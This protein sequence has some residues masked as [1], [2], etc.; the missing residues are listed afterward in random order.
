MEGTGV[1]GRALGHD[2]PPSPVEEER[3]GG[4]RRESLG[5]ALLQSLSQAGG[6]RAC[7]QTQVG[8]TLP[9][10]EA[11]PRCRSAPWTMLREAG[12]AASTLGDTEAGNWTL[13]IF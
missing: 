9:G 7:S 2:A 12:L 10:R 4:L 3:G 13:S 5:A 11:L 6:G 8:S 1:R